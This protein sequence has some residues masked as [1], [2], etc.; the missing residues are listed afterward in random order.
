[1]K[2]VSKSVLTN[3]SHFLYVTLVI[4]FRNI[5]IIY[6]CI[7]YD[8]IEQFSHSKWLFNKILKK[9]EHGFFVDLIFL[10]I[11]KVL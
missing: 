9:I 6:V 10:K 4:D 5:C 3:T 1:M 2:I 8:K 7:I 11:K